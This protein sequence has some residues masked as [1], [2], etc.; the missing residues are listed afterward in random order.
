MTTPADC[1]WRGTMEDA[2]GNGNI[3]AAFTRCGTLFV[4]LVP[5]G[6]DGV[7]ARGVIE[8]VTPAEAHIIRETKPA[9]RAWLDSR[10][11]IYKRP[12][13]FV[14]LSGKCELSHDEIAARVLCQT[15]TTPGLL[16]WLYSQQERYQGANLKWTD[17]ECFDAAMRDVDTWQQLGE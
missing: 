10:P 7:A 3:P 9:I 11:A 16:D 12:P 13:H 2:A 5:R 8:N 14:A 15:K 1:V 4:Q 17:D 6:S